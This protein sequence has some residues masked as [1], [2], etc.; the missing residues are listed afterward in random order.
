MNPSKFRVH[1]LTP[2]LSPEYRGEGAT[3][4]L[5]LRPQRGT[6]QLPPP[7]AE[8][9]AIQLPLPLAGEGWGE[10]AHVPTVS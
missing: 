5:F 4:L 10:G 6:I 8:E 7:L 2:T 3:R 1:P 9:E